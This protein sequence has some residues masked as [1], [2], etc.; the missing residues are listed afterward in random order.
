MESPEPCIADITLLMVYHRSSRR[1]TYIPVWELGGSNRQL[2]RGCGSKRSRAEKS[3]QQEH[4]SWNI[5]HRIGFKGVVYG[6]FIHKK[7]ITHKPCIGDSH[8]FHPRRPPRWPHPCRFFQTVA[9]TSPPCHHLRGYGA[10]RK[11]G[12]LLFYFHELGLS[13]DKQ[14]LP[15]HARLRLRSTPEG[16]RT[17]RSCLLPVPSSLWPSTLSTLF[18]R[19]RAERSLN[20]LPLAIWGVIKSTKLVY[21]GKYTNNLPNVASQAQQALIRWC[22]FGVWLCLPWRSMARLK[23]GSKR[24]RE[25]VAWCLLRLRARR[26]LKRRGKAIEM[27]C[28]TRCVSSFCV[29]LLSGVSLHCHMPVPIF[30]DRGAGRLIQSESFA[31]YNSKNITFHDLLTCWPVVLSCWLL[32]CQVSV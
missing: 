3:Q 23:K 9:Q 29:S 17:S 16:R 22:S 4:F 6:G 7:Y 14:N 1:Y 30:Y 19:W 15:L 2:S 13:F 24:Q 5:P 26:G 31:L 28:C 10:Q 27:S 12:T 8:D 20:D 11:E 32:P 18:P 21:T 25:R